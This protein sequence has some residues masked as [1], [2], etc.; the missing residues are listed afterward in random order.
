[1]SKYGIDLD[2]KKPDNM[3]ATPAAA[4]AAVAVAAEEKPDSGEAS[5]TPTPAQEAR[6]PASAG[7]ALGLRCARNHHQLARVHP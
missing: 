2:G 3:D 1:M 6:T 7:D 4:V 5:A